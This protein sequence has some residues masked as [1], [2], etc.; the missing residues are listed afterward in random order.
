MFRMQFVKL[1]CGCIRSIFLKCRLLLQIC[2]LRVLSAI[3]Y[4]SLSVI[5][6]E[7]SFVNQVMKKK[8]DNLTGFSVYQASYS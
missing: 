2:T 7:C 3:G 4:L 5:I 8:V 6:A 1:I